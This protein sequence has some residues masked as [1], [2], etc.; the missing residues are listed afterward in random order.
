[1]KTQE[2]TLAEAINNPKTP[3]AIDYIKKFS[4]AEEEIRKSV[5]KCKNSKEFKELIGLGFKLESSAIQLKRG[6]LQFISDNNYTQYIVYINGKVTTANVSGH[7][8]KFLHKAISLINQPI[9]PATQEEV[10][11]VL[12]FNF[13][14]GLQS[15][16]LRIKNARTINDKNKNTSA[17]VAQALN[18]PEGASIYFLKNQKNTALITGGDNILNLSR[19]ESSKSALS[20]VIDFGDNTSLGTGEPINVVFPHSPLFRL[21]IKA[22]KIDSYSKLTKIIS[23]VARHG[24]LVIDSTL[25]NF[26]QL[27]E[28]LNG[29]KVQNL[30]ITT[31]PRKTAMLAIPSITKNI[32]QSPEHWHPPTK[33]DESQ[34]SELFGIIKN[35]MLKHGSIIDLQNELIDAGFEDAAEY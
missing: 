27:A 21:I 9:E 18:L 29:Q 13:K 35:H 1:M 12:S 2:L 16:L 32:F 4:I 17:G 20:L 3:S 10:L 5:E 24:S 23:L 7:F 30:A 34:T 11:K 26:S 6:T 14:N 19:V 31:D 33:A 8:S 15:V 28:D 22:P 25:P